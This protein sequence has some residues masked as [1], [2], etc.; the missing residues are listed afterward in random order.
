[1]GTLLKVKPTVLVC[2]HDAGGAN[3]LFAW[4]RRA[5]R[6]ITIVQW[7]AGPAE[8]IFADTFVTFTGWTEVDCLV[9]GSGWQSDFERNA[10][11]QVKKRSKQTITLLDHWANYKAR[12][13]QPDASF[14]FPDQLLVVDHEAYCKANAELG[15]EV[16]RI[17]RLP[18]YY[19]REIGKQVEGSCPTQYLLALEPIRHEAINETALYHRVKDK[20]LLEKI[21]D[22]QLIVRPHPSQQDDDVHGILNSL[23]LDPSCLSKH[24]LSDD[25]KLSHTVIGFQTAVLALALFCHKRAISFFP[26]AIAPSVLPHSDIEYWF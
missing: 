20:L 9:T 23:S 25:L 1:M 18:N 15:Y 11:E 7:V 2:A 22:D 16:S 19:W 3:L 6:H 26:T 5:Q 24:D 8:K 21:T 4:A 17:R 13:L 12:F 10:L 14:V